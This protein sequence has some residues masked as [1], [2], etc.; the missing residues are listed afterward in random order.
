MTVRSDS[1]IDLIARFRH[2]SGKRAL[3]GFESLLVSDF[4]DP[5][6]EELR[7]H[8]ERHDTVGGHI[9][10]EAH[11]PSASEPD[12]W[13]IRRSEKLV[14]MWWDREADPDNDMLVIED[15]SRPSDRFYY[16]RS[17]PGIFKEGPRERFERERHERIEAENKARREA[18]ARRAAQKAINEMERQAWA[19][20]QEAERRERRK[21]Y[22]QEMQRL[23]AHP[24]S[25]KATQGV[26]PKTADYEDFRAWLEHMNA[27]D[28]TVTR[29]DYDALRR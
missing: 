5:H 27:I 23:A 10:T 13:R 14:P 16:P 9:L 2:L 6:P 1:D 11:L 29:A 7:F 20:A 17:W 15:R 22:V 26:L 12:N 8:F 4:D 18:A 28:I 3:G 25:L 21:A 19:E 24:A